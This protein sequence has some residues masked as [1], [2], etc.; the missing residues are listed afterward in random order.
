MKKRPNNKDIT[1]IVDG[2]YVLY[3]SLFSAIKI[4]KNDYNPICSI[5][6]PVNF[7]LDDDFCNIF[8]SRFNAKLWGGIR[9]KFPFAKGENI[10]FCRDC[11]KKNIWR[12]DFD[13]SY[14]QNRIESAKE[15]LDYDLG[16]IFNYFF[17]YML[18]DLEDS[19]VIVLSHY[20]CEADDLFFIVSRRRKTHLGLD[21]SKT[22]YMANDGDWQMVKDYIGIGFDTQGNERDL[23]PG[24][25]L[26]EFK[27]RSIYNGVGKDGVPRANCD[28]YTKVLGPKTIMKFLRDPKK[29]SESIGVVFDAD[30]I[31]NNEL[32]ILPDRI[33]LSIQDSVWSDYLDKAGLKVE[34]DL[35]SL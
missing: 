9:S 30:K 34:N 28:T 5:E 19:G 13:P 12:R 8:R 23:P 35:L 6:N 11:S 1:I 33:P 24:L 16:A 2:S 22:N 4:Y 27:L 20:N 14:K 7:T 26:E 3:A 21:K 15:P 32:M 10:V 25:T 18:K 17:N 31:K 29:L